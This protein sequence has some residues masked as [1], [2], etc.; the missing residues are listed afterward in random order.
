MALSGHNAQCGLGPEV[1]QLAPE[2]TLVLGH[3]LIQRG[4]ESR[5][6]PCSCLGVVVDE[7]YASSVGKTHLPAAGKRTQLGY[8][9]LLN[10]GVVRATCGLS[11]AVHAD[12]LLPTRIDP[13]CRARVVVHEVGPSL[14]RHS[15]FPAWRKL[16]CACSGGSRRHHGDRSSVRP[17]GGS[18]CQRGSCVRSGWWCRCLLGIRQVG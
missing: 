9:L 18:S 10:G 6:I 7:I 17:G 1:D 3:T 15:S 12:V 13:C 14:G 2:V 4:G 8:G 16:P 11:L 5:I